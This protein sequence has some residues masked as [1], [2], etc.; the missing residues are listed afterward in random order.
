M[1]KESSAS[2][3]TRLTCE[4]CSQRKVKCDKRH[5]CSNCHR[6]GIQC[7]SVE[8]KRLPRG[9]HKLYKEGLHKSNGIDLTDSRSRIEPPVRDPAR[10]SPRNIS[11]SSTS[12]VSAKQGRGFGSGS[13]EHPAFELLESAAPQTSHLGGF[14]WTDLIAEVSQVAVIGSARECNTNMIYW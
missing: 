11:E 7:V 13:P 4:T 2:N 1:P 10:N 6:S 5:P 9:R 14:S 3:P 8:R 12:L